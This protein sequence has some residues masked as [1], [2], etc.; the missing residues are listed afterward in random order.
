MLSAWF[1]F[2]PHHTFR[3]VVHEVCPSGTYGLSIEQSTSKQP[4][5]MYENRQKGKKQYPFCKSMIQQPQQTV[6]QQMIAISH[7]LK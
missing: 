7:Q 6:Q 1:D 3:R 2:T 5:M 4:K